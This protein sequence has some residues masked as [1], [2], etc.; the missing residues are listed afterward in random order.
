MSDATSDPSAG[1]LAR[2][3]L[4]V[5]SIASTDSGN[6]ALRS[7]R[8]GESFT[9][10]ERV[11]E[12]ARRR[13]MQFVTLSDHNTLEGALRIAHLPGTF[14]SE[15]VT[16]RFPEDDVILHV[17]VWNL[18]ENDHADLQAWRPSVY[19]LVA[20][21][22]ERELPHALAHPLYR[23]GPPLTVS[24]V[25]RLMLLF[26]VWEGRNGARP[27]ET[28]ELAAQLAEAATPQY[29]QK[30]AERHGLLPGH[31]RIAV[32]GGSDD[33]AALDIA[34]TWTEVPAHGARSVEAFLA[35][36][37]RGEGA[38]GGEHGATHKLAHAMGGLAVNAYRERGG[39][40][41]EPWGPVI[42]ELFD[43]IADDA[44]ERHSE[45]MTATG[46][47]ARLMAERARAAA[48]DGIGALSSVGGRLSSLLLAGALQVPY[49]AT[50]RHH[51]SARADL[52]AIQ[53]GFFGL[54][55][56]PVSPRALVFTDTYAETNGVAGTM[57]RIVAFARER[58][59]PVTVLTASDELREQ[60]GLAVV[61]P[62]WSLPLPGYASVELRFPPLTELLVRVE[63][64]RPDVI[65]VA[66]PGPVG[67]LGVAAAKLL[68][69]P[70]VGSYHTELGPYAYHLT[71][72]TL[73]A[74]AIAAWTDLFYR[75]CDSVLAP[76]LAI[77]GELEQRGMAGRVGVWGRGVDTEA[78]SPSRRSPLLRHKLLA[79]GDVVLLSVGRVSREKRLDVLLT[80][81]AELH[82]TRPGTRL[83][84]VGD[85]PARAQ[86]EDAAGPGVTFLG[87]ARGRDL[88]ALYASSDIFCFPSTTDTFGQVLLEAAA[89]GLPVVAA[90]A[91][92][93][94]ELVEDGRTGLL[95]APG[96]VDALAAALAALV[97]DSR[98]RASFGRRGRTA[99]RT[100]TW[101]RAL[102]ELRA[103]HRAALDSAVPGRHDDGVRQGTRER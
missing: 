54:P 51:S 34:T 28:N 71:Q 64:E 14:L 78:F 42:A 43:E 20:F 26:S 80:A 19:D 9:A 31:T 79:G 100:R 49:A 98:R 81:F 89:S 63:A 8:V 18:G 62:E 41:P 46:T 96:D 52:R 72:D 5:H 76:T 99:A 30:L 88:A 70:L 12:T 59:E 68:G 7:A 83:V 11:Y 53:E 6:Y 58:D 1:A 87:E 67:A 23:M 29:L 57:R 82:A 102:L 66:T 84:I 85:G 17:L 2:C 32:T 24:H 101:G 90:A 25:E 93:A 36:V 15:E 33:H 3:D 60:P 86:L 95:V 47:A 40:L 92:G 55:V 50:Q 48:P 91:G 56:R 44:T 4:H 69:V 74:G 10:P 35:A 21:L 65:Q 97:D 16:T 94:A 103:A 45:I 27:R 37:C 22:R 38:P 77:A 73:V 61:R 13:G 75:Q 39:V